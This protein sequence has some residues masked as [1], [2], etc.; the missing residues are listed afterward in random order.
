MQK[1]LEIKRVIHSG[2]RQTHLEWNSDCTAIER[3]FDTE[4]KPRVEMLRRKSCTN[5][6][7]VQFHE[8][9]ESTEIYKPQTGPGKY[10]VLIVVNPGPGFPLLCDGT[11]GS[12]GNTSFTLRDITQIPD[13]KGAVVIFEASI[14]RKEPVV[15]GNGGSCIL[16]AY[17]E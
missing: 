8:Y 1:H 10:T 2:I 5:R 14:A 11:Q 6:L 4:I 12:E 15:K 16:L 9:R 17:Q 3:Y 7:F 13:E